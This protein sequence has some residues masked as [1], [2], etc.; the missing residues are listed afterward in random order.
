MIVRRTF[1]A[2][3]AGLLASLAVSMPAMAGE[4]DPK[5]FVTSLAATAMETMTAKGMSDQDRAARFR[6]LFTS[7]VDLA[8]I[9]RFVLGRHWKPPTTEQQQQEFLRLFT[10]I[11]VFT[12]SNRF[13]D[14]GGDLRHTVVNVFPDPERGGFVVE[15]KVERERQPPIALQWRLKPIEDG[16]RVTDLVVEGSSMAI[17]YRSEYAAVIQK[18]NGKVEG[19]L[20]DLRTKLAELGASTTKS[21]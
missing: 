13:K 20:S 17:H 1:L 18:H 21:N 7:E 16:L 2:A 5:A 3:L 9:G 12:W 19:L 8:E 15:S 6:S 14:Y 11:V 10:D 4:K